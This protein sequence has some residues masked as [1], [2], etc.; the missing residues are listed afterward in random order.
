[1]DFSSTTACESVGTWSGVHVIDDVAVGDESSCV[2]VSLGSTVGSSGKV[3]A[4][5]VR[6]EIIMVM[7]EKQL[8]SWVELMME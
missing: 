5:L 7:V 2:M 8:L 4:F 6:L 1:M 3:L